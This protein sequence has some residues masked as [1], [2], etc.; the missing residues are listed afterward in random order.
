M[1]VGATPRGY[2][3]NLEQPAQFDAAVRDFCL[4]VWT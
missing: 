3:R 2:G 1:T 4:S